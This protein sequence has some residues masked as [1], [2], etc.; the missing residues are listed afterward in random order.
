MNDSAIP[1]AANWN[2]RYL[3]LLSSVLFGYA[4]LGKG[5]AYLGL[6]PLFIGEITLLAGLAVLLGTKCFV[7]SLTAL[8]SVLLVLTMGWVLA[9]T[10]PYVGTYG[11]DALRDSVVIFYGIFAFI[12]I[13]LLMEDGARVGTIVQYYEIFTT[14]FVFAIPFVFLI[15]RYLANY[16]PNVPWS[17]IPLIWISP[18]ELNVH[19]TGAVVFTLVGFRK[20]SG[21]WLVCLIVALA[22]ASASS[23]G[24]VLA[25]VL[26]VAFAVFILGRLRE[27]AMIAAAGLA[28][29]A[30]AYGLESTLTT[31]QEASYS[32]ERSLSAH[33][34]ADNVA[35][36]IGNSNEQAAG[37]ETWRLDWWNIILRDT[38]YGGPHFWDGRGFGLNLAV[39]DGFE[40]GAH[41]DLPSLR[42]P[43]NVNMTIL[44]RS[45]APGVTLWLM[46]IGSWLYFVLQA[47]RTAR[48]EGRRE[49]AALFLFTACYAAS[50]FINAS[51]DVALEG[52]VQGIW[53]WSVIGLG[54]GGVFVFRCQPNNDLLLSEA[55]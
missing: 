47:M 32:E 16:I 33:Q 50:F 37:T 55:G 29:F 46:F 20:V 3:L 25:F 35:S 2:D 21:A 36:I 18:G 23:R 31:Y 48:L 5:F 6:P 24:A 44:A 19:L 7:A 9:R 11:I 15:Q 39:A 13:A 10:I 43:H 52:P 14:G 30:A 49:W 22:M 40:D 51:F 17:N 12:V 41:P 1:L 27:L 54:I 45:G 4:L 38:L 42:S 8:P 26:P 28:I 53:F 34:I